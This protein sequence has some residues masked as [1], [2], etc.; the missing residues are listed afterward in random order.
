MQFLTPA[1]MAWLA[2][3]IDGHYR[4]L[5]LVA[6]YDD[7]RI[8]E[9]AGLRHRRVDLLRGTVEVVEIVTEAA[10]VLHF[11][12]PKTRAGRRTVGCPALSW[13]SWLYTWPE[14]VAR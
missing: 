4:A 11:G 13:T 12:P 10:A 3:V 5:V 1:E 6:A 8:G 2:D 7:L 14:P 9:L